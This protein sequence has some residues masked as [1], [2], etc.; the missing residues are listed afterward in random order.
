MYNVHVFLL[1]I[2]SMIKINN[3]F[4]KALAIRDVLGTNAVW[5]I[6]VRK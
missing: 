1:Y 4:L 3:Y 5:Q 6:T 2:Y